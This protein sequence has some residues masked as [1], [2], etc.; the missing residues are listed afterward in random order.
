MSTFDVSA[1]AY[2]RFMGRY[3][4]QLSPQLADLAGVEAGQTALD[5]GC[6]PGALTAE[7]VERLG[8]AAV[9][10]VDPSASFVDAI[11]ERFPGV[12]VERAPAERLPYADGSF[13][14]ALAQLVVHFMSDPVAGLREMARVTVEGGPIAVCGWDLAGDCSPLTAFWSGVHVIVP[15]ARDEAGMKGSG[16]GQLPAILEAA[17][18]G[19]VREV[20]LSVEVEHASFEDWWEPYTYGVGPAGAF[21][22]RLDPSAR[23][24]VREACREQLGDG[25]FTIAARSWAATGSA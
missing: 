15:D 21:V 13:D 12:A 25:P 6:G 23:D 18:I 19:D 17:G 24:R 1:A 2:D 9:C 22:G 10:A 7:L 4:R 3:S 5:V 14:A 11:Q 16:E 20:A 8:T